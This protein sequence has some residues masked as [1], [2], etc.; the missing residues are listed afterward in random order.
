MTPPSGDIS[1]VEPALDKVSL[2][3]LKQE[4]DR[5]EE[6]ML[7][8]QDEANDRSV[9]YM[10]EVWPNRSLYTLLPIIF[11]AVL[12]FLIRDHL[13]FCPNRPI[14]VLPTMALFG[15]F[16]PVVYVL[17]RDNKI[18]QKFRKLYPEDAELIDRMRDEEVTE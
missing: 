10:N 1:S 6:E 13:P 18:W 7:K 16:I 17:Y 5:R 12:L 15:M 14:E 4:L 3:S 2:E 11:F 9:A 8:K